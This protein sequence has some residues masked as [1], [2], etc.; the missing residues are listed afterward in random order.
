VESFTEYE[1]DLDKVIAYT[2][3]QSDSPVI[4]LIAH[5]MGGLVTLRY[6]ARKSDAVSGAV[7][8]A[9]LIRAAVAVPPHKLIIARISAR[10]APRLRLDNEL[11]P[12]TLSRDPEVG[13]AY[14]ADPL[15]NRKI[16]AR[17]FAEATRAMQEVRMLASKITAPLLMLQGTGDKIVSPDATKKF[18]DLI[19]SPD[20]EL[21]IYEGFYHELFNEPEKH[22][23]YDRVTS[24]LD[25]RS[26]ASS[27]FV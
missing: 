11:D 8:S 12:A 27:N 22:Q 4:Y 23:I 1:E 14:A 24:W 15:V 7:I 19:G 16:S 25:R 13:K 3:S 5:S 20:K 21:E 26:D 2:R 9:P 18:F 6:L 10:M 17:W